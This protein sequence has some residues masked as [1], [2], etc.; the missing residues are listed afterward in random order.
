MKHHMNEA[1]LALYLRGDLSVAD[2]RSM[3]QHVEGCP[4]CQRT[5]QE[6]SQSYE[7][8]LGS[9]DEP[10]PAELSAVRSAVAARI[11]TRRRGPAWRVWTL[12]ASA[13]TAVIILLANLRL[14]TQAPRPP[15]APKVPPPAIRTSPPPVAVRHHAAQACRAGGPHS[16]PTNQSPAA[17][18]PDENE[19]AENP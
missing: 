13:V 4:E 18:V 7:L 12:A 6:L 17:G 3:A 14:Q 2:H 19:K 8:L 16:D 11:Q 10:T 5:L 9:F 1:Q 15:M